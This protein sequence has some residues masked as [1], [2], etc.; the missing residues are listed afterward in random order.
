M[1]VIDTPR[2]AIQV[3]KRDGINT[4]VYM[5]VLASVCIITGFYWDISWHKSIG[6]DGLFSPPHLVVYAGA[7][8]AGVFSGYNVI[9]ISFFG[10]NDVK[11]SSV[12]FWGIFYSSVGGLFCIWG[13][14]AMLTSAPFDDWWHDTY[15]LD[16]KVSSP[17]HGLLLTGMIVIQFGAYLSVV[18]AAIGKQLDKEAVKRH[19]WLF[20]IAA[21]SVLASINTLFADFLNPDDMH[22]GKFYITAAVLFP[23]FFIAVTKASKIK[24]GST[25]AAGIFMAEFL[26]MMWFLQLFPAKP[27]LGPVLHFFDHYQPFRFPLLLVLPAIP[28]DIIMNRLKE[29][30]P[31]LKVAAASFAFL[32]VIL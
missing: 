17:P 23:V 24:W 4:Y 16:S 15:G 11:Q 32:V 9:R 29:K 8:L 28:V 10:D 13:A 19:N 2:S 6:R 18:T 22:A 1:Q 31:I 7:I 25:A 12:K 26:I 27:R 3:A 30:K 5:C 14:I 20:A 21:G